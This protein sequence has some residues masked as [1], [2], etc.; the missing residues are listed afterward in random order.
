[1]AD[2]FCDWNGAAY[3]ATVSLPAMNGYSY[4]CILEEA[5]EIRTQTLTSPDAPT[6]WNAVYMEDALNHYCNLWLDSWDWAENTLT[7]HSALAQIQLAQLP[8]AGDSPDMQPEVNVI[9]T[10]NG[11]TAHRS[12]LEVYPGE[13]FRSFEGELTNF[14]LTLPPLSD[15]DT[16]SLWLEVLCGS[17]AMTFCA[18][19][20]YPENGQLMLAA[21]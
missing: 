9:L 5:G 1:M 12:A 21:G 4:Y 18:A 7:I 11:E 13:G 10:H 15:A 3:T 19:E 8:N 14:S 2:V 17:Q 16:V 6:V 20:W